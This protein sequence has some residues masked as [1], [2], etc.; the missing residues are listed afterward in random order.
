ML[1]TIRD[2]SSSNSVHI[3]TVN[4]FEP[5]SEQVDRDEHINSLHVDVHCKSSGMQ[6]E[7]FRRE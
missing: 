3:D 4:R 5:L 7:G 2:K 6:G 1:E